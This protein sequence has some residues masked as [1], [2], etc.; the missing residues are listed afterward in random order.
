MQ[1]ILTCCSCGLCVTISLL[2]LLV[3]VHLCPS[4]YVFQLFSEYCLLE[5]KEIYWLFQLDNRVKN[6]Y[7]LANIQYMDRKI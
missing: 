6:H 2:P 3:C 7:Y 1:K 5:V 4:M